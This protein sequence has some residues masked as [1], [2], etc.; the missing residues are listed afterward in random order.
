MEL[1]TN[2]AT[3]QDDILAMLASIEDAEQEEV[4]A[5]AK[6]TDE[7]AI[8]LSDLVL[9]APP[10]P[11]VKD[12]EVTEDDLEELTETLAR[13]AAYQAQEATTAPVALVTPTAD[14]KA[15]KPAR[16]KAAKSPKAA[17]AAKTP[18]KSLADLNEAVFE[19]IVG[20]PADKAAVLAKR[21]LQ[22]KIAEKFDNLFLA[23]DAGKEP[24]SYVVTAMKVL[25]K[26]GTMTSAD[27]I[28]AYRG[29]GL[30]DGTARS[31]TGQIMELFNVVGIALRA[32]QMLTLRADSSIAAR[33]MAI[34]DK[35]AQP[36]LPA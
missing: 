15:S 26:T 1:N 10:K 17:G 9:S 29:E 27:L 28:A 31:Q 2:T 6:K 22:V 8:D 12:D 11:V 24:S 18:R 34:I 4:A 7:D 36:A 21:P 35:T 32:G 30:K 5:E 13:Q 14:D 16:Q 3:P 19:I 25:T 23:L 33:L 20:A